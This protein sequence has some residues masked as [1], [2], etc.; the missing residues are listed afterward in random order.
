MKYKT[1]FLHWKPHYFAEDLHMNLPIQRITYPLAQHLL[2]THA[3]GA[4]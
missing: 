1:L 4:V 2:T 3:S